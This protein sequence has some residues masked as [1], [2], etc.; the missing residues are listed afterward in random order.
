[1]ACISAR[2]SAA[3][4]SLER[5]SSSASVQPRTR[6]VSTWAEPSAGRGEVGLDLAQGVALDDG[7][8]QQAAGQQVEVG[9]GHL[10][11]FNQKAQP[12]RGAL[13]PLDFEYPSGANDLFGYRVG[14]PRP[15]RHLYEVLAGRGGPAWPGQVPFHHLGD[16]VA[17]QFLAQGIQVGGEQVPF[18][19]VEVLAGKAVDALEA[20]GVGIGEVTAG[21]RV[22]AL[23]GADDKTDNCSFKNQKGAIL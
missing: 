21:T 16:G 7:V 2:S 19:E 22:T 4:R 17:E 12:G 23:A 18:D 14:D 1:M 10:A 13:Y 6:R 9:G 15:Q 3:R 8:R 11:A 5:A 20:Q